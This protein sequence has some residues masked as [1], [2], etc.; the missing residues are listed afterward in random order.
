MEPI[1]TT[2]EANRQP[3][4]QVR[5]DQ[6]D[7]T[8]LGTDKPVL[9]N[10]NLTIN[11]GDFVLVLGAS[12]SGKSTFAMLLNG[13]I[14]HSISGQLNGRVEVDGRLTADTPVH[15]LATRVG[16]V[17]QDPDAQIVNILVQDEIHFGMENLRWDEAT[18]KRTGTEA[19]ERLGIEPL[20]HRNVMSLSGGQKQKVVL[21]SVLA[22][23]PK[24][25][26]LDEPTANLDPLGTREV[27]EVIGRLNREHHITVVMVENRVDELV[28]WVTRVVLLE[29]GT[30][31]LDGPPREVYQN[32]HGRSGL[33]LP[34]VTEMAL[35]YV[36]DH[37][38]LPVTVEE[39]ADFLREQIISRPR[40]TVPP[41]PAP[42]PLTEGSPLLEVRQL[43]FQYHPKLP[44]VLKDISFKVASGGIV[45]IVGQNGSGKTT[46][47]RLLVRIQNPS[48]GTIFL[49][50]E[51][52]RQLSIPDVSSRIG[53]VF[54]NPDH[55]FVA[56]TVYDEL[57]FSL[58]AHGLDEEAVKQRTQDMLERMELA[59]KEHASPFSLSVGERRRLSVGTMLILDQ[60]LVILDEPTIGQDPAR[61]QA[62]MQLLDDLA[63]RYGHTMLLITHDMRLVADWT[64]RTIVMNR[65]E[66]LYD[67]HTAGVFRDPALLREAHLV[68]P[69]IARVS[70]RLRERLPDFPPDIVS[71]RDLESIWPPTGG[72]HQRRA[73][74]GS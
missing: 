61:S 48:P 8:Y 22:L 71:I 73:D 27:F 13:L 49:D 33:W 17:F 29:N 39:G 44:V 3:T 25:L 65:G 70:R 43:R 24:L 54:Q 9:H 51:D 74:Y 2:A 40:I 34:Q 15:E 66:I 31:A 18:I 56:D 55:Q 68:E 20:R 35:K 41:E 28:D 64:P 38:D 7:F 4:P 47:A 19:M 60:R 11:E 1:R 69:P 58:R 62:L 72:S 12:G 16:L 23:A 52:I 45:A 46:L 32:L 26:V 50:G 5:L 53:Y 67:G 14:P 42:A 30:I 63:V 21:A 59:D 57:A 37:P 36:P 10:L 6:V